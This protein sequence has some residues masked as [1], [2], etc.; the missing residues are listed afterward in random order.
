MRQVIPY[1]AGKT[2]LSQNDEAVF[3][4]AIPRVVIPPRPDFDH[5]LG[6]S[7]ESDGRIVEHHHP[8][9][10]FAA[11]HKFCH[12]GEIFQQNFVMLVKQAVLT[13]ISVLY[14]SLWVNVS[15]HCFAV[16]LGAARVDGHRYL[17]LHP[18][19]LL[20]KLAEMRP[21]VDVELLIANL[22]RHD[23][24]PQR[25]VQILDAFDRLI[26]GSLGRGVN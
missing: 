7:A 11:S 22:V 2:H 26:L 20:Q 8:P 12:D 21:Q 18:E 14:F 24:M 17:V 13:A 25:I 10:R 5:V 15:Q 19:Q 3:E 6:K 23:E 16:L 1:I 9:Q 4:N